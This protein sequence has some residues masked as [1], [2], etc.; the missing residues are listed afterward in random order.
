VIALRD[1]GP[2][3]LQLFSGTTPLAIPAFEGHDGTFRVPTN[4][5]GGILPIE[6]VGARSSDPV[7]NGGFESAS[8]TGWSST[9]TTA[10]VSAPI[11]GTNAA[12][13]GS[14]SPSGTSSLSQTF[15]VPSTGI[16]SL[17]FLYQVRCDDTVTYDQFSVTLTDNTTLQTYTV[18]P[19]TC[20]NDS[21]HWVRS[22]FDLAPVLGHSVTLTFTNH[23]DN[24]PGD[25]TYTLVDAVAVDLDPG[26]LGGP[27]N[28][29]LNNDFE[30]SILAS[31]TSTGSAGLSTTA[32]YGT[33][34]AIVG[35]TSASATST[36]AQTFNVPATGVTGLSFFYKM[37]CPDTLTYDQFTVTL[38]DNVTSQSYTV[39][40]NTCATNS[41]W[42]HVS[43]ALPSAIL[44]HGATLTFSNHDDNN[45]YDASY[46]LVDNVTFTT[47][48]SL[49]SGM[50]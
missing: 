43:Y 20:T 11:S 40:P 29:I 37:T 36:L 50:F 42:V 31:W 5:Q 2:H 48:D 45:P 12:Q 35:S 39:V 28:P 33:Q 46:T 7:L 14:P 22:R 3:L 18:V 30:S 27:S 9:G 49:L 25:P 4:G 47:T 23:D 1:E 10:L 13:V 32:A 24:Y 16:R 15:V 19:N 17:T 6:N 38:R 8:L 34:S 26:T 44:G 21:V 41:S